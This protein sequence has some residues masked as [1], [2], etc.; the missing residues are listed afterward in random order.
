MFQHWFSSRTGRKKSRISYDL[1]TFLNNMFDFDL[2][3]YCPALFRLS[4]HQFWKVAFPVSGTGKKEWKSE[5]IIKLMK[6]LFSNI[7]GALNSCLH[8]L[9]IWKALWARF[10]PGLPHFCLWTLWKSY[11]KCS[12]YQSG[13][14]WPSS[15]PQWPVTSVSPDVANI[16]AVCMAGCP[17]LRTPR[18]LDS[19]IPGCSQ[20]WCCHGTMN[21]KSWAI[22]VSG[23]LRKPAGKQASHW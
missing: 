21:L 23:L 5:T 8:Q 17:R 10:P 20:W 4:L 16:K 7:M 2:L 19:L 1:L 9:R 18:V 12:P 6:T 3:A 22:P 15:S 11:H 14:L 13:C